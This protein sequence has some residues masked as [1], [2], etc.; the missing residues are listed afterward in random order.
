VKKFEREFYFNLKEGMDLEQLINELNTLESFLNYIMF[1]PE[2]IIEVHTDS[3]T[4]KIGNPG[5]IAYHV[6]LPGDCHDI[7]EFYHESKSKIAS[8]LEKFRNI[9]KVILTKEQSLCKYLLE[10]YFDVEF[11]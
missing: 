6:N 4:Y 1:I 9:R 11:E 2:E 10:D 3:R 8:Q 5:E 7:N